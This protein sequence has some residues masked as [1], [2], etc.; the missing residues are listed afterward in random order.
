MSVRITTLGQVRVSVADRDRPS[1]PQQRLRC[2]LLIYLAVERACSRES[3]LGVFWPDRPQTRARRI[4]SQSL[5]ELRYT[6]G[7]DVILNDGD[8]VVIGPDV[9]IDVRELEHHV[10][11]GAVEAALGA[12]RGP[13][14]DGFTLPNNN[15]F[16]MWTERKRMS[17]ERLHRRARRERISALEADRKAHV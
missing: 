8:R 12:Y 15:A 11:H 4:L 14:L 6:L 1:V 9:A 7:D 10:E 17:A 3:L 16:D 5:Y 13:F 2:A